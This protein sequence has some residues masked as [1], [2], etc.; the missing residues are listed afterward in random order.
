MNKIIV[1][2]CALMMTVSA[3]FAQISIEEARGM[4]EGTTV[5]I[6][7]TVTNGAELGIIRYIQDATGAIPAYPGTG[8]VANFPDNVKRGDVIEVT[9]QL[10][11]YNGLLE[12]DP[13]TSYLIQASGQPLPP[14]KV[15]TP[16]G[17]NEENEAQLLQVNG[18]SFENGGGVFSVGNYTISANGEESEIYVR[19]NHPLIGTNIPLAKVNLTGISSE[20]NGIYQLLPRDLDDMVIADNFYINSSLV[21]SDLTSDGFKVSWTTNVAGSSSVRYGTD[22]TDLSNEINDGGSTTN[23]EV[24][25]TGLEPAEFYY[26]QAFSNNGTSTVNSVIDVFS[27]ASNSSGVLQIY[28]NHEVDGTVSNG[29]YANDYTPA[30]LEAAIINRIDNA[31]A[32]IDAS[33]YNCNRKSI[34]QAL[35]NAY[36]RGVQVRYITDLETA[37]LALS[38]PTPPFPIVKGNPDGLMHNKFFTID[39]ASDTESWVIMG[40]TNMT[41]QN[42]AEDYNHMIFLQDKAIAKCYTIEF[43]EMWGTSGAS[44]GIFN[45]KFGPAKVNNTPQLFKINDMEVE[46]YFSPSDNTTIGIVNAIKSADNDVQFALLTFT[47]N[48]LGTAIL[49]AHND[50]IEVRGIIDNV[51]DQGTEFAYLQSNGVNVTQDNTT[52][53]THHKYCIVD[54]SSPTSDPQVVTGSHNWSGGAETRN[55]ENTLIFHDKNIANIFLQEFEARWCEA[56]GGGSCTTA[57][58][59]L[60][61]IEGFAAT[62][63][64][65]PAVEYTNIEFSLEDRNDLTISLW[66][67]TGRMIQSVFYQGVQGVQTESLF[68]GGLAPGNYFVTFNVEGKYSVRQLQV[69]GN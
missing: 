65:N 47:N 5:T 55:D 46:S 38:D 59:D 10:K 27:T 64:P 24:T 39:A 43:E 21:Q 7:G 17:I 23:H 22:I 34:I 51:N 18:V 28:F 67:A 6:T 53:Q 45:Q 60:E 52:T 37:N 35:S 50:G 33:V 62:L 13:I 41:E 14:A 48:E 9:G 4:A 56:Q 69:V 29:A 44:P 11:I 3:L 40:S 42:I 66:D 2:L 49:N 15:V 1:T 61:E 68:L 8:S 25:L 63:F 58:E 54:A 19:S 32:T 31:K 36:N 30:A 16:S 57:N 20:F 12:I 26:V